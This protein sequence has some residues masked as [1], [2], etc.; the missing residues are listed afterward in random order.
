MAGRP[1]DEAVAGDVAEDQISAGGG[2]GRP[3]GKHV[4][5]RRQLQFDFGEVLREEGPCKNTPCR[6]TAR[7]NTPRKNDN[8][9]Q[10]LNGKRKLAQRRKGPLE[11]R[12][13]A[14]IGRPTWHHLPAVGSFRLRLLI[15]CLT[16]FT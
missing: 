8:R 6:N 9:Q 1:L 15:T 10:R 4:V 13:A 12:L 7:K 2:P 3:F 16:P 5:F 14:R 11:K